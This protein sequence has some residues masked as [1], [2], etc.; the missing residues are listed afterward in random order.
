MSIFLTLPAPI[1]TYLPPP[2]PPSSTLI[3]HVLPR[4]PAPSAVKPPS[5]W[6]T[7]STQAVRLLSSSPPAVAVQP[8][9]RLIPSWFIN[10]APFSILPNSSFLV[11]CRSSS[12]IPITIIRLLFHDGY[13]GLFLIDI[14]QGPGFL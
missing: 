12:L 10:D 3:H 2:A 5:R 6:L 13:Y 14:V 1:P 8:V 7:K 4:T 11:Q 9:P